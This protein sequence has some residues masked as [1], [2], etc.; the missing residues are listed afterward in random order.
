M[1]NSVEIRVASD[2]IVV[3]TFLMFRE[4]HV[5]TTPL[6]ADELGVAADR[7]I[8][9]IDFIIFFVSVWDFHVSVKHRIVGT[10]CAFKSA[11][12][13]CCFLVVERERTFQSNTFI[14]EVIVRQIVR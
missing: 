3:V 5:M 4:F 10:V 2:D 12:I 1:N 7:Y 6:D 14:F 11:F 8:G 9:F 13:F